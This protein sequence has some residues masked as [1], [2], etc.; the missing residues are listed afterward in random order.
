MAWRH[1]EGSASIVIPVRGRL[2]FIEVYHHELPDDPADVVEML[3]AELAPLDIWCEF[4][5][6]YHTRG[7]HQQFR[8]D[9]C[10]HRAFAKIMMS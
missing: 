1:A 5:V 3:R 4:A 6:A 8:N 10:L 9:Q 7:R 2:D